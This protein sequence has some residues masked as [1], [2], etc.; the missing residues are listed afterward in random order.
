MK[1]L[2][3]LKLSL[4]HAQCTFSGNDD[5]I[6]D[7]DILNEEAAKNTATTEKLILPGP[8]KIPPFNSLSALFPYY[9]VDPKSIQ[10]EELMPV[11][12]E[13]FFLSD[14]YEGEGDYDLLPFY[15]LD[16]YDLDFEDNFVIYDATLDGRTDQTV[17]SFYL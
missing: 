15:D 11:L 12:I 17:R 5:S 1:S 14:D 13:D 6:E 16:N 10:N 8:E 2:S 4:K 3:A 7:V 9:N